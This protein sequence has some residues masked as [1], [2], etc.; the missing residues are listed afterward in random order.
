MSDIDVGFYGNTLNWLLKK[1]VLK[2]ESC[3]AVNFGYKG[4]LPCPQ[5]PMNLQT[6]VEKNMPVVTWYTDPK[7]RI[8]GPPPVLR[9]PYLLLWCVQ[10]E[11]AQNST[12][13]CLRG[14]NPFQ[15]AA[16]YSNSAFSC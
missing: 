15:Y 2:K 8:G 14:S 10:M 5:F 7:T 3:F 12:L 11:T 1:D 9:N 13:H 4:Q 16:G 6:D